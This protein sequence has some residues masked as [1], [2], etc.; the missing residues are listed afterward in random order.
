MIALRAHY[1]ALAARLDA[2]PEKDSVRALQAQDGGIFYGLQKNGSV[3][4]V[5]D[6][7]RPLMRIQNELTRNGAAL[8]DFGKQVLFVGLYPG[9]ELLYIFDLSERSAAPH[10]RQRIMVCI[11]SPACLQGF[12]MTYD[13]RH[14]IEAGR[15]H[16]F[17]HEDAEDEVLRIRSRPDSP[18]SFTLI[19]GAPGSVLDKALPPFA[20]LNEERRKEAERL[21]KENRDYYD[22]I[23]D[24][25]LARAIAGKAG[26]APRFMTTTCAW[27]T[28]VQHSARDTC[29]SFETAGW[30]TR[31]LN[32][33]G[34]L[35]PYYLASQ[36]NEF[37]PDIFLFINHLRTEAREAYPDNMLFL[38]WI[39]DF[40]PLINKIETAEEW[41]GAAMATDPVTGI[42]RRRDSI[43]GYVDQVRKY[44][45]LD[46]RLFPLNM[47]VNRDIFKP[48]ELSRLQRDKYDCDV[49]FASNWIRPFEDS[50]REELAPALS[51]F[52][53]GEELIFAMHHHLRDRYREEASFTSYP[54]LEAELMNIREF[55]TVCG[56][57][58]EDDRD[59][60]IQLLFWRINDR[61]YREIVLEWCDE[62]G[63]KLR[64]YGR[65]WNRHPRL[66]AHAAGVIEHGEELSIAYQAARYSLHL[67]SIEG[68][69]QRLLEITAS[70]G[71]PITRIK[72]KARLISKEL[73]GAFRNRI[74]RQPL[75]GREQEAWNSWAFGAVSPMLQR[76]SEAG[77]D[78]LQRKL[79]GALHQRLIGQ[80]DW[81]I[82]DW[83]KLVF[84]DKAS[85]A[86]ILKQPTS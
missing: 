80:P 7:L 25:Q 44:G 74:A 71:R 67:N 66:A 31:H 9:D 11:D 77:A 85:L 59:Q 17:W 42:V 68:T 43:V 20:R 61:I 56:G 47:I 15:V 29:G 34:I 13:A 22:G 12:L 1:P 24:E 32:T 10:A 6:H 53:I 58:A 14:V 46:E 39:Q 8:M 73:A 63:M 36:I 19:T 5:T 33:E 81:M 52:S 55:K 62:L 4:P 49:C 82:P 84:N 26:R 86:A 18:Y 30:E 48:R 54:E 76:D 27:S 69:H 21:Q 57:L 3:T 51:G 41:T 83:E 35:T 16:F 40:C 65:G 50:V 45:Y 37:K 38:T 60:V 70:G 2:Y 75:S 78:L 72:N 79:R 23:S 64:L 28:V